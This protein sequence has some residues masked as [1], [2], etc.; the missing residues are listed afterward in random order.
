MLKVQ[1][2]AGIS[3][4]HFH[5]RYFLVP[6]ET[7]DYDRSTKLFEDVVKTRIRVPLNYAIPNWSCIGVLVITVS[8]FGFLRNINV[9][10]KGS[11]ML[12]NYY[13]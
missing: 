2:F 10:V 7:D 1:V 4:F 8:M 3:L 12:F 13:H 9:T 11:A 6:S 5:S